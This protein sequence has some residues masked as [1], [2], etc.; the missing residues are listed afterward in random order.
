MKGFTRKRILSIVIITAMLSTQVVL[1]LQANAGTFLNYH[2]TNPFP[3]P[4]LSLRAITPG[5]LTSVVSC[6]GITNKAAS[7][8]IQLH[9]AIKKETDKLLTGIKTDIKNLLMSN[10]K[11][12]ALEKQVAAVK[13]KALEALAATNAG[14]GGS[15]LGVKVG[16][17]V[18]SLVNIG[19]DDLSKAQTINV[20]DNGTHTAVSNTQTNAVNIASAADSQQ[21]SKDCL[22]GI[23][24][25]LIKSQLQNMTEQTMNWVN[26]GFGGDPMYVTDVNSFM[27]GITDQILLKE[28]SLFKN[29]LTN[30]DYPYGRNFAQ[31][32]INGN[33][34]LNNF[35][36]SM[37]QD[38]TSYLT[39]GS[40]PQTFATDF[41]QGG[42]DGWLALTQHPQNNPLGFTINETQH[43]ADLQNTQVKNTTDEINRN[44]GYLDQKKCVQWENLD[45]SGEGIQTTSDTGKNQDGVL[46]PGDVTQTDLCIK[47]QTITP[48]SNIKT[49]IDTYVNTPERQIELARTMDDALNALFT[50]LLGQFQKQ[51]LYGL[52]STDNAGV[53]NANGGGFGVNQVFDSN[54]NSL[55]PI[56]TF[57]GNS[58]FT[59]GDGFFDLTKDLGNTYNPLST[60][61][62]W[63]I[64]S[65]GVL[66]IQ[67]DYLNLLNKSKTIMDQVMPAL[68]KLD[69][70]IPGPNPD[71]N[72]ISQDAISAYIDSVSTGTTTPPIDLGTLDKTLADYGTQ[73]DNTYGPNSPMQSGGTGN[74]N[75]LKMSSEGLN[76]TK[77]MGTYADTISS[78]EGDFSSSLAE[79]NS[80]IAKL[81]IIKD[82]VN[83]IIIAAQKRRAAKRIQSGLPNVSSACL[84]SERVT[85]LDNGVIK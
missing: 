9:D 82:K 3:V 57:S 52:Q 85:Y 33:Q 75:Y 22:N 50:A 79:A 39:P 38:L 61:S 13:R 16:D 48:G 66:Q 53:N 49:K 63:I 45:K 83:A 71:W 72:N 20:N 26:S 17:V 19:I 36:D 65:K 64:D 46:R 12:I 62:N 24:N 77:D 7:K 67:Y 76:I 11:K 23:A 59:S 31:G 74:T 47:W 80:N 73:I 21:Q 35:Q 37:K 15:I 14:A 28:T 43:I 34:A 42:W 4:K 41:S 84:I 40:T 8:L 78:A 5:L 18:P 56:R 54:G 1:P 69:Y 68:G 6:T 32:A 29:P 81:N 27:N 70:C 55:T 60:T 51:G 44:S 2:N 58:G 10:A 25:A 30:G